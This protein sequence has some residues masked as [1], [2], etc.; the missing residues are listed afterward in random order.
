MKCDVIVVKFSEKLRGAEYDIA[1][2]LEKKETI[3]LKAG[4]Y[5]FVPNNGRIQASTATLFIGVPP[6]SEFNYAEIRSFSANVLEI[7]SKEFPQVSEIASPIH[8]PGYGLDE[9]ESASSMFNG[10]LDGLKGGTYPKSIKKITIVG[11]NSRQIKRLQSA[12]D[13]RLSF[14]E[15]AQ[16]L[17]SIGATY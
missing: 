2:A 14:A 17:K 11:R 16:R 4:D 3:H 7:L 12:F 1:T 5:L 10:F 13:Q 8:G 15:Y 6:L 9:V